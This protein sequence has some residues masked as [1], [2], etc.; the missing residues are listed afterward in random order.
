MV[1]PDAVTIS[2]IHGAK[3]LEFAGVFLAANILVAMPYYLVYLPVHTVVLLAAF[4]VWTAWSGKAGAGGLFRGLFTPDALKA[5]GRI[6]VVFAAVVAVFGL[7]YTQ[8]VGGGDAMK[9]GREGWST[10]QLANYTLQAR[11]YFV[12]HPRSALFKGNFKETYWDAQQI[13]RAHV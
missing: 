2:T 4:S 9:T 12:P 7:Y 5:W 1:Q 11:D 13:G 3:G 8:V 10:G 6:A